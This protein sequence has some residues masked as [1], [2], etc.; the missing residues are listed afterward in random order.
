[1]YGRGNG[2][3]SSAIPYRRTPPSWLRVKASD[4][5]DQII[6]LARK[7]LT[8]SSIGAMLRD[9]HG[10]PQVKSITGNKILRILKKQG[11]QIQCIMRNFYCIKLFY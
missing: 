4:V 3:S 1:M 9:S 8:P 6:K 10:I 2:I 5:E 11:K 7:G